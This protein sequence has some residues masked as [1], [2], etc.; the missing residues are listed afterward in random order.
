MKFVQLLRLRFSLRTLG[1]FVT[2]VCLYFG[3]WELTKNYAID[4]NRHAIPYR[5][6]NDDVLIVN[7]PMPFVMK[8]MAVPNQGRFRLV[9][10]YYLWL[11]GPTLQLPYVSESEVLIDESILY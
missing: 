2:L 3:I 11:L 10:R 9:E 6:E 4:I 5:W 8:S 1:I 7:A